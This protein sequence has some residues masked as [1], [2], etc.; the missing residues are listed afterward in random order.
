MKAGGLSGGSAL[1]KVGVRAMV[2]L[3]EMRWNNGINTGK[4]AV[5]IA[6]QES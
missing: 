1:T 5:Y 4:G 3:L 6:G 2:V